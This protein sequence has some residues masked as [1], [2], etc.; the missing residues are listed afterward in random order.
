MIDIY[1][2]GFYEQAYMHVLQYKTAFIL[3]EMKVDVFKKNGAWWVMKWNSWNGMMEFME[4]NDGM[5][6]S[7]SFYDQ[8]FLWLA[9]VND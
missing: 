6:L 5:E 3:H 8:P 7:L 4:W 9:V 2:A 1:S